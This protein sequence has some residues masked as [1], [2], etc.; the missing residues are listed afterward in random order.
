MAGYGWCV[1][2]TKSYDEELGALNSSIRVIPVNVHANIHVDCTGAMA[3]AEQ[4]KKGFTHINRLLRLN[5]RPQCRSLEQAF[6]VRAKHKADSTIIHVRA[7][8]GALDAISMGNEAADRAAKEAAK[9][10]TGANDIHMMSFELPFVLMI[11]HKPQHGDI[12]DKL[13]PIIYVRST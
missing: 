5:S 10:Q 4:A 8:T 3:A 12:I 9:N 7:H 11:K 13:L 6:Y 2:G 1:E